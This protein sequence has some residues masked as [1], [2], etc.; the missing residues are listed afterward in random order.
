M[1]E[2][3]QP[4]PSLTLW[5]GPAPMCGGEQIS[6]APPSDVIGFGKTRVSGPGVYCDD[7]HIMVEHWPTTHR[8]MHERLRLEITVLLAQKAAVIRYMNRGLAVRRWPSD[9]RQW[10]ANHHTRMVANR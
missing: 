2:V 1:N 10:V 9:A 8:S 6:H 3:T 5:C 7:L 4:V